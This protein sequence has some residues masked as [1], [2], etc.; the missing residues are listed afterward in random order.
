MD[1]TIDHIADI[2][3]PDDRATAGTEL[4]K[5]T[6]SIWRRRVEVIRVLL[7]KSLRL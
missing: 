5:P 6:S 7:S 4:I 3:L 1:I 2:R